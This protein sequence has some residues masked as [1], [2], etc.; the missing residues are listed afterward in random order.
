MVALWSRCGASWGPASTPLHLVTPG[1]DTEMLDATESVYGRHMDTSAWDKVS[2]AE[3]AGKVL[4]AVRDDRAVL[5]PG[6]KTGLA[7]V[8]ARGPRVLL[9]VASARMF[10]RRP[11]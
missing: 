9:D 4:D 11:R 3:W 8:A 5:D 2:P 1:V 10:S 6:G 7:R